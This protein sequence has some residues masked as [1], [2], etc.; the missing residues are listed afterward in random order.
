[1]LL[2]HCS[3]CHVVTCLTDSSLT[4]RR[5]LKCGLPIQCPAVV[6]TS[7]S[8]PRPSSV[9]SFQRRKT[10]VYYKQKEGS[11]RRDL[12]TPV[13]SQMNGHPLF[14]L[15][16]PAFSSLLA[17]METTAHLSLGCFHIAS[18]ASSEH[19]HLVRGGEQ[20]EDGKQS[21]ISEFR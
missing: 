7:L 11:R 6:F 18:S 1:M 13:Q 2:R 14:L 15:R 4:V 19:L 3:P 16:S 20:E 5:F 10:E 21:G 12:R 9:L 8:A 17:V